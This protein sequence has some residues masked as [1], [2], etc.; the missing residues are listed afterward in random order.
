MTAYRVGASQQHQENGIIVVITAITCGIVLLALRDSDLF[1]AERV[2]PLGVSAI[3]LMAI[4]IGLC[5][6]L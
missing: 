5:T 6:E 4:L 2:G 3:A 1:P